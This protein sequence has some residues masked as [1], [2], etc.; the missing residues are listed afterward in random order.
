[1]AVVA[2][3]KALS[4]VSTDVDDDDDPLDSIKDYGKELTKA[5][6][7]HGIGEATKI[8]RIAKKAW[9]A[10]KSKLKAQPPYKTWGKRPSQG[11]LP[12]TVAAPAVTNPAPTVAPA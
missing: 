1:L 9:K 12:T 11:Y 8:A 3:S 7:L 6:T 4:E 5:F 10:K 2:F